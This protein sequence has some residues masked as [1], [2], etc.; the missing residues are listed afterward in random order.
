MTCVVTCS[1]SVKPA[2]G[3][4]TFLQNVI[5]QQ[6]QQGRSMSPANPLPKDSAVKQELEAEAQATW[7]AGAGI[8]ADSTYGRSDDWGYQTAEGKNLLLRPE[9]LYPS[10][11]GNRSRKTHIT[12]KTESTVASQMSMAHVVNEILA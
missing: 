8:K 11:H 9:R 7:M 3:N 12:A 2:V 4:R 1:C 6:I 10:S 5:I